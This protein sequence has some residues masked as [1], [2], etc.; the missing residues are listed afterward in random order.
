LCCHRM[1]CEQDLNKAL[2]TR[3]ARKV[4]YI[5]ETMLQMFVRTP[6]GVVPVRE[7]LCW[8]KV[9][10]HTCMWCLGEE[11]CLSDDWACV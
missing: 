2:Y 6:T 4:L 5:I 8:G 3:A 10:K 9:L 11:V 7:R 1:N